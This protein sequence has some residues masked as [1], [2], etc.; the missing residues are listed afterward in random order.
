M[1]RTKQTA[2]KST[3]QCSSILDV[4]QIYNG[5]NTMDESCTPCS[6][7]NLSQNK[8]PSLYLK[9]GTS[10]LNQIK[11]Y[12]NTTH[13]LIRKASFHRLVREIAQQLNSD[14]KFQV[15]ALLAIQVSFKSNS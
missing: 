11:H 12:Q 5:F 8:K 10:A 7:I 3:N 2:R 1:V 6:S 15:D 4:K 9:P 14:Y 13:L